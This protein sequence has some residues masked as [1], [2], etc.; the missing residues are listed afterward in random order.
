[1]KAFVRFLRGNTIALLALFIALGGT[2]YA[3]TA[4]PKNSVGT[5]QLKK[6]AVTAVKIKN[7]N[8]TGPKLK[9]GAVT[10][11][12]LGANAVTGAKVQDDSLTGADVL[13]SS[14][15]KVPAAA[16]ADQATTAAPSGAAGGDLAGT[17]PNPTL[18]QQPAARVVLAATQSI[19][20]GTTTTVSFDTEA[21]D[22]G[23]M[24]DPAAPDRLTIPRA[25]TYVVSAG[26]RFT[27]S[28]TG[29]RVLFITVTG[30]SFA[31]GAATPAGAYG[32]EAARLT[33][34]GVYRFAAGDI[35]QLRVFQNSGGALNLVG[36][37][38]QIA[39]SAA[40][41]GP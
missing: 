29:A 36:N 39:L 5:T 19:P 24:F 35:V 12:K 3:A 6:N 23:N 30:H 20:S 13:E 10:N 38:Q 16:N 15:G 41:L 2:T 1:M 21:A 28:D 18:A 8:V 26:A 17:Y 33:A 4:L 7:G 14:L 9:N 27:S 11:A 31:A 32:G 22:I 25:G 34:S 37:D 40:W